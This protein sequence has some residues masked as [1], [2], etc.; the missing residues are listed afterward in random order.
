MKK[1][2]EYLRGV[3]LGV[4]LSLA[5]GCQLY[6]TYYPYSEDVRKIKYH[7]AEIKKIVGAK[8]EDSCQILE[9][10]EL[11]NTVHIIIRGEKDTKS[12]MY[13]DLDKDGEYEK[14]SIIKIPNEPEMRVIPDPNFGEKL[15]KKK[16]P[17]RKMRGRLASLI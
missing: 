12:I 15:F 13:Q 9:L 17:K 14:K 2:V 16:A 8:P 10:D 7:E 6:Q 1:L 4:V 5:S 11:G 3:G